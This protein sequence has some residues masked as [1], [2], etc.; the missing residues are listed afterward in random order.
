MNT[1][2]ALTKGIY[3]LED[4]SGTLLGAKVPYDGTADLYSGTRI[5]VKPNQAVIFVYNGKITEVFPAGSHEVHTENFPLLTRLANWKFGFESPL[6]CE[7]WFIALSLFTGRRWGTANP[8]LVSLPKLGS[9]PIR[10]YGNYNVRIKDPKGF[11]LKMVGT[12][13]SF[14]ITDLETLIQGQIAQQL[15]A[16][17]KVINDPKD[18][19]AKQSEVAA[20]LNQLVNQS[21]EFYG[22]SVEG[23][24]V[25]SILPPKE[26]LEA[27]DEKIAMDIVGDKKEYLLYKVANSLDQL[28]Q[29]APGGDHAQLMMSLM[30][31]KGLIGNDYRAKEEPKSSPFAQVKCPACMEWTD[32][33]NQFCPKCGKKI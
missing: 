1:Q 25:L 12:Q 14:D 23:I 29:G 21:F 16:A 26:I 22:F 20:K 18:L 13:S 30:M 5:I 3:E 31:S 27:I 6:R 19:S 9:I 32:P 8:V 4:P 24:Q 15:P 33:K 28:K 2:G 10:A 17:L 11:F 7:L